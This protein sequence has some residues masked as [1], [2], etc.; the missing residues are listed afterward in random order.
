MHMKHQVLVTAVS[1]CHEVQTLRRSMCHVLTHQPLST[2]T[3][4]HCV[5]HQVNAINKEY[6]RARSRERL[7]KQQKAQQQQL[8]QHTSTATASATT[9]S[10]AARSRASSSTSSRSHSNSNSNSHAV[11]AAAVA[12]GDLPARHPAAA[13]VRI[14][15]ADEFV[16]W[17]RTVMLR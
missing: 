1:R 5:P 17:D 12:A 8:Q 13:H 7:A 11:A 2:L 10:G 4:D 9:G 14:T 16:E 6:F 15:S 3:H